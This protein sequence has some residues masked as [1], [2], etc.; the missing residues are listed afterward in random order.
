[1]LAVNVRRTS[2]GF[3]FVFLLY[4]NAEERSSDIDVGISG[5][6]FV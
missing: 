5:W 4:A 6:T 2:C 1:M 3:S